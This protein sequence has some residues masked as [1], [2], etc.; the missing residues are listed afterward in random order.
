ML[1]LAR[2]VPALGYHASADASLAQAQGGVSIAMLTE[3]Q[4][5]GSGASITYVAHAAEAHTISKKTALYYKGSPAYTCVAVEKSAG[6]EWCETVC[7]GVDEPVNKDM[8][9]LWM[10]GQHGWRTRATECS[11]QYCTCY[12]SQYS[13]EDM[14]KIVEKQGKDQ[15]SGLPEC[16]WGAPEGC[17]NEKPYECMSGANAGT[18][19]EENWFD[20]P[21]SEC[22]SSCMHGKLLELVFPYEKW[23]TGESPEESYLQAAD[24]HYEHDPNKLTMKKRGID[25]SKLNKLMSNACQQAD[26]KFVGVSLYSPSYVAKTRRLLSSC[27]RNKV[28]CKAIEMPKTMGKGDEKV[29]EGSDEYRWQLIAMKPA[30]ILDQLEA[31]QLPVVFLDTDLEFHK[32]PDLFMPGSWPQGAIDVGVFNFWGNNSGPVSVGSGLVFFNKTKRSK[33]LAT[34]WA[35][36]MAFP[37]NQQAPDDQ[38][39]NKLLNSPGG[40][41]MFRTELGYLPGSYLRHPP[42]FYHGIDPVIDHDHGNPPGL[43]AHSSSEPVMPPEIAV[44]WS[45]APA[46][47]ADGAPPAEA[48]AVAEPPAPAKMKCAAP[49]VLSASS[50]RPAPLAHVRTPRALVAGANP[51]ARPSP[52]SGARA[53]AR[54]GSAPRTCAS[55][56]RTSRR[57]GG[58]VGNGALE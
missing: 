47:S 51:S 54:R 43:I 49:Q 26:Q 5:R 25:T 45:A 13:H 31:N 48:Q 7:A 15:P 34:A 3:M 58:E 41:W 4:S 16:M 38:V 8:V 53:R 9:K 19:S 24:P 55:A 23:V 17:S 2:A 37:A 18:C 46:P 22:T 14:V 28:C 40:E 11:P 32:F 10:R 20:K 56:R 42:L 21:A 6:D 29:T 50:V 36:A 52:R 1:V 39:L 44:D 27:D 12:P 35:E 30:F 57:G 33:A